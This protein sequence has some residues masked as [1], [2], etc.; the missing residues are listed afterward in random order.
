VVFWAKGRAVGNRVLAEFMFAVPNG[1][2]LSGSSRNRA[3]YMNALKKRGLKPGVSDLV[4]PYPVAPYHG[5]FLELKLNSKS[6]IS[7][8]QHAW[9]RLM[10]EVGYYSAIALG[11]DDAIREIESYLTGTTGPSK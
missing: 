7:D 10:G 9:H 6:P 1:L 2:Q 3:R 8:E 4:V 5:M 11:Y